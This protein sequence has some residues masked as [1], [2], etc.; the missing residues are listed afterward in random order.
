MRM[1]IVLLENFEDIGGPIKQ[2]KSAL[3]EQYRAC[4]EHEEFDDNLA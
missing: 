4:S 1:Q 2:S 3:S